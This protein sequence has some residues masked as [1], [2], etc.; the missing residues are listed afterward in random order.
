MDLQ[1]TL[2][3]LEQTRDLDDESLKKLITLEESAPLF[4][5]ALARRKAIYGNQVY[6]RGLIE[7]TNYCKNNCYYCGLRAATHCER[8]RLTIE[9]ILRCTEVGYGLGFRT[10]VLQGGEDP[11]FD[12]ERLCAIVRAIKAQHRDCMVTLSVGERSMA[13]YRALF[14]A[15]AGRYLLRHETATP[16]HYARLHPAEMRLAHRLQCLKDLK[17]I[18]YQVGSGFM[19]G[20][21]YQTLEHLVAD[22]RFLQSI[23]PD[24]IG[25]GPFIPQKTTPFAK[26]PAGSVAITLN[27][28]SILRLMFPHA[29]I[30]ST[31]ALAT[32]SEDG[33]ERGLL[34]GANV[35]M[36]NLS[37]LRVRALYAIYDN[38]AAFG[39]ESA[40]ALDA[41]RSR[42]A[43][44]GFEVVVDVG[45]V[46]RATR[47][48]GTSSSSAVPTP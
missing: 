40:Q 26:F 1:N 45:N 18:G 30:P 39:A 4:E 43:P 24:M 36:P 8:Y 16:E 32:L 33:R 21:P 48:D 12:D 9:E 7:L 31:T 27:L 10:F 2:E 19:V 25:I 5:R 20:S 22:L 44:L 37:P 15:G 41:L 46:R 35:V 13:S 28:I 34:A 17:A 42:L 6:I 3:R 11:W 47:G 38:K 23:D 29:L 14:E